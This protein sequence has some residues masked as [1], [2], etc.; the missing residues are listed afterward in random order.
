M[1]SKRSECTEVSKSELAIRCTSPRARG[2]G[3]VQFM[4]NLTLFPGL[5]RGI[6]PKSRVPLTISEAVLFPY[7]VSLI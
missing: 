7:S 5:L 1:G 6:A 3:G 2:G 4:E